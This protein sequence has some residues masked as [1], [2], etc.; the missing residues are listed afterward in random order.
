M[1]LIAP[2]P[3]GGMMLTNEHGMVLASGRST[4]DLRLNLSMAMERREISPFQMIR[5]EYGTPVM[6]KDFVRG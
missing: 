3:L 6:L 2:N 4:S 1:Y 5:D